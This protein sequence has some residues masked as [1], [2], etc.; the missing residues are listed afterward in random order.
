MEEGREERRKYSERG[1]SMRRNE[2]KGIFKKTKEGLR[3]D[4][5]Y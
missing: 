1:R 2:K 3:R 5:T 4:N